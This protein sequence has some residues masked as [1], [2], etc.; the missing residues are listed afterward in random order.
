MNFKFLVAAIVGVGLGMLVI[1][2]L[3][4]FP[5]I[6]AAGACWILTGLVYYSTVSSEKELESTLSSLE[7]SLLTHIIGTI[8]EE[9]EM[10]ENI[11]IFFYPSENTNPRIV[12]GHIELPPPHTKNV[13]DRFYFRDPRGNIYLT[14]PSMLDFLDTTLETGSLEVAERQVDTILNDLGAAERVSLIETPEGN[15]VAAIN[16]RKDLKVLPVPTNTFTNIV[17]TVISGTLQQPIELVDF[18][19]TG[20]EYRLHFA[21]IAP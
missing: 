1:G 6:I 20:E 21:V 3:A 18:E 19:E 14:I 15:I 16:P 12:L 4:F 2:L 7:K 10:K 17:G 9:M 8:L 11:R 5:S 13:P